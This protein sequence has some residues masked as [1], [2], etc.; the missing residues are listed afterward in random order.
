MTE[1]DMVSPRLD[2][3]QEPLRV[4]GSMNGTQFGG[5]IVN[6]PSGKPRELAVFQQLSLG[7]IPDF[8]RRGLPISVT[9]GSHHGVFWTMPDYLSIGEDG[10]FLRMPMRP[11][12]AQKAANAFGAVLPTRK[13]A[14][15]IRRAMPLHIGFIG[16][17]HR[18]MASVATF[19]EHNDVI[20]KA[21]AGRPPELGLD[22]PKKTVVI[23]R[24]RPKENVA[25]YG[26]YWPT[27]KIV[28]GPEIQMSAH[29]IEYLDY[30]H[31]IRWISNMMFVDDTFMH[32]EEVLTHPELHV[33]LSD[34]GQY[35]LED[36]YYSTEL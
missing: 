26:G 18:P 32:I 29:T 5:S 22:G 9:H 34:E 24:K 11:T 25:I 10:D 6:M 13:M 14:N 33:L 1:L 28:Q 3:F 21:V 23:A 15:D 7:N 36:C 19:G 35:A 27:G 30:S 20:Q 8:L 16:M 12:T 17:S 4:Q 31:G 2:V